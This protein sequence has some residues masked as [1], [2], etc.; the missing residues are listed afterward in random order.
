MLEDV[1]FSDV[2][3]IAHKADGETASFD[4]IMPQAWDLESRSTLKIVEPYEK[5]IADTDITTIHVGTGVEV[6]AIENGWAQIHYHDYAIG[7]DRRGW[8]PVECL[9]SWPFSY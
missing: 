4:F 6:Y 1:G 9:S 5:M 2:R 3:R 8:V 7:E